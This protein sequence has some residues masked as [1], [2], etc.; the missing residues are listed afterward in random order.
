MIMPSNRTLLVLSILPLT[1]SASAGAQSSHARSFVPIKAGDRYFFAASSPLPN[2]SILYVR[3]GNRPAR[4]LL[5]PNTLSADRSVALS[6]WM[7]SPNGKLL[8]Y[9]VS[10]SGSNWQEFRVRDVESGRDTRDVLKWVKFSDIS[11]TRDNKGF[12]YEA[13]D[14]PA[15]GSTLTSAS[16]N[17]RVYYHKLGTPQSQDQIIFDRKDKPGWLYDA[18]VTEDGTFAMITIREGTDPKARVYFVFLDNPKKPVVNAP[19]VRLIDTQ[20]AEYQY[21]HNT[22]DYFLFRTTLGAP[23]GRLVQIDI[24]NPEVNRWVTILP[25]QKDPLVSVDIAGEQ[26]VAAY[27]QDGH[28]TLRVYGTPRLD[29]PRR[30]RGMSGPSQRYPGPS[31]QQRAPGVSLDPRMLSAPGYPFIGEIPLPGVGRIDAVRGRFKDNELFYSF[32]SPTHP[33]SVIRYDMKRRTNEV[34]T[35]ANPRPALQ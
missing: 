11:W 27:L 10:A 19:I 16:Q 7:P 22:G 34:Y 33:R 1:I 35:T 17:Q 21:V 29:D 18:Q 31:G 25:E 24:N 5:D 12:F 13:F 26:I 9:G 8:G 20:D 3:E 14:A 28:S 2:Q 6:V 23:K 4:V 30:S 32:V 15:S